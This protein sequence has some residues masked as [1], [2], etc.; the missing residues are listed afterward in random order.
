[1]IA[2]ISTRSLE[3]MKFVEIKKHGFLGA[4]SVD[5]DAADSKSSGET[6]KSDTVLAFL[7][8]MIFGWIGTSSPGKEAVKESSMRQPDF[9]RDGSTS[10]RKSLSS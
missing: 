9:S 8:V 5:V 1:M 3:L 4:K 6:L 7:P 10:R 2:T